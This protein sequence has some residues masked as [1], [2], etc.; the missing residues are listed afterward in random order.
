[1]SEKNRFLR[2]SKKFEKKVRLFL[3]KKWN[4][5][6]KEKKVKIGNIE[7]NFDLVS[8]NNNYIGDVKYYKNIKVPAAKWSII[9]EYVWLLEKTNAK[10]KFLI[11]GK[12]IEVPKR[13]LI[14]FGNLTSVEF[15][16]FDGKNFINLNK[17]KN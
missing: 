15:Y 8:K 6:L 13:W 9:A 3:S 7:K 11:F 14:R 1:M 2:E 4:I 5:G 16:F 12:D 17:Q 10:R